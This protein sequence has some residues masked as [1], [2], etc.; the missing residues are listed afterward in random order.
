M[1]KFLVQFADESILGR[2]DGDAYVSVYEVETAADAAR[3]FIEDAHEDNYFEVDDENDLLVYELGEPV[4][5]HAAASVTY[6]V[7]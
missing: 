5:L 4:T 2:L 7:S 1:K 3:A 6:T